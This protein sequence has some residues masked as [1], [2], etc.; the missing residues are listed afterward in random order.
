VGERGAN[1]KTETTRKAVRI[2]KRGMHT[3]EISLFMGWTLTN[4]YF[5]AILFFF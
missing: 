4:F 5:S 2:G 3:V 1:S